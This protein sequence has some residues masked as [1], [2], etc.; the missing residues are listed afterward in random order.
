[1]EI[2]ASHEALEFVRGTGGRLWVWLDPHGGLGSPYIYL[3]TATEPPGATKATRRLRSARRPHRF[4]TYPVQDVDILLDAGRLEPQQELHLELKRF[5]RRRVEAY[6][7]G[8]IFVG[9]D[10]PPPD[11]W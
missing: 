2:I 7:N 4:R 6:W 11:Q 10:I 8:A 9:E 1:V 3:M 5:P